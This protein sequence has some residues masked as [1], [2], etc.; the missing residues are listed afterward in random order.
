MGRYAFFILGRVGAC[1]VLLL[2]GCDGDIL[3]STT[4]RPVIPA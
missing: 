2:T 3:H 4:P 1:A